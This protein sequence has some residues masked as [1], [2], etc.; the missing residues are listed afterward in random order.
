VSLANA[1]HRQPPG[2]SINERAGSNEGSIWPYVTHGSGGLTGEFMVT[3]AVFSGV[4]V[5]MS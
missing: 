2:R 5:L 4:D 1:P 3:W